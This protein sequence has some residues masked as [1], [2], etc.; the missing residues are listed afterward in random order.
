M[1]YVDRKKALCHTA[2]KLLAL[3]VKEGNRISKAYITRSDFLLIFS[4]MVIILH[5]EDSY[6]FLLQIGKGIGAEDILSAL[7]KY[8]RYV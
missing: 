6:F 2:G 1:F 8:D 3:Y 4:H 7:A 5:R